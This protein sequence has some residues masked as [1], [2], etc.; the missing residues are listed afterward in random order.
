MP[1][2]TC[3]DLETVHQIDNVL[4]S[5]TGAVAE[6]R[7]D[8]SADHRAEDAAG[9]AV[10]A[11][12]ADHDRRDDVEFQPDGHGAFNFEWTHFGFDD[13]DAAAGVAEAAELARML[14]QTPAAAAVL[15]QNVTISLLVA[16]CAAAAA[17]PACATACAGTSL[18][19]TYLRLP[20]FFV[21]A[22]MYGHTCR[23][24]AAAGFTWPAP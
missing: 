5:A 14:E 15:A 4:V 13:D 10:Q 19:T 2:A 12:A 21:S 17:E 1:T 20:L 16:G 3:L 9:A 7:H 23:F 22:T 24:I 11:R 18:S 8:Q 6:E